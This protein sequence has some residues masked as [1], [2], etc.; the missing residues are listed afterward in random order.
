MGGHGGYMFETIELNRIELNRTE[1]YWCG[2]HVGLSVGR[3][4]RGRKKTGLSEHYSKRRVVDLSFVYWSKVKGI[5]VWKHFKIFEQ[6]RD[7]GSPSGT[8]AI[9][10]GIPPLSESRRSVWSAVV[11]EYFV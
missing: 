5:Q 1:I 10:V 3:S 9:V 6:Y 11:R 2:G 8:L 4:G 7:R